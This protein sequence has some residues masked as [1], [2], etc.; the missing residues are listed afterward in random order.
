MFD[1]FVKLM[2]AR[3]TG[4]EK[5][6]KD[7]AKRIF[8]AEGKLHATTQH[9]ADAAGICRTSLHYYYKSRDELIKQVF[10]EAANMLSDKLHSLMESKLGFREKIEEMISI[11]LNETMAYPYRETFLVTEMLSENTDLYKLKEEAAPH[12]QAFLKE[13]EKEMEAGTITKMRPVQFMMNLFALTSYPLL[14]QPLQ[15]VLFN[16]SDE[17]Y[18]SLINERKK[19]VVD[20]LFR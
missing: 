14:M 18:T 12:M 7:T 11:V 17:Q 2:A 9:I 3:D 1:I 4:T 19:L 15:K 5:L 13:V 10:Y 16:L 6:I 20:M 8:F